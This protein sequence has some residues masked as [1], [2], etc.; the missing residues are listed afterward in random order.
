[1]VRGLS[2]K[3]HLR[4]RT[5][6]HRAVSM[7]LT[8]LPFRQR[9]LLRRLS[10]RRGVG[11]MPPST[12]GLSTCRSPLHPPRLA[13]GGTSSAVRV[14]LSPT[15]RGICSTPPNWK[16]RRGG[17]SAL[18]PKSSGPPRR[19]VP[20][21]GKKKKP[22]VGAECG[23]D[24]QTSAIR[25]IDTSNGGSVPGRWML[26]PVLVYLCREHGSSHPP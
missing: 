19:K 26:V 18:M 24:F 15:R 6:L 16:G 2:C 10:D 11:E 12:L 3:H 8:P 17:A 5:N 9:L 25:L 13:V 21:A 14:L 23:I 20:G 1:M 22:K 7:R 4:Y